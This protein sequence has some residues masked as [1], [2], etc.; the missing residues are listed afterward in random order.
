MCMDT[1]HHGN[2][3]EID[4]MCSLSSFQPFGDWNHQ[5]HYHPTGKSFIPSYHNLLKLSRTRQ[6]DRYCRL[7]LK[8]LVKITERW[9]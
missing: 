4:M 8:Q 6:V 2:D 7:G 1:N 9:W 5:E 3:S